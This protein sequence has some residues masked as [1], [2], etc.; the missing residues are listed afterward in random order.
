MFNRTAEE[1]GFRIDTMEVTEDHVDRF[2]EVSP[3]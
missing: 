1:Y 3:R 2:V